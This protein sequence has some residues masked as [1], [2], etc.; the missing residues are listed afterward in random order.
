MFSLGIAG[1]H[2]FGSDVFQPD[3]IGQADGIS[4]SWRRVEIIRLFT[5]T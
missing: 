1:F 3:P 5:I 2:R 4:I